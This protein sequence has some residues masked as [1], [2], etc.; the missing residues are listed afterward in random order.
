M[1]SIF[2]FLSFL[3]QIYLEAKYYNLFCYFTTFIPTNL[4]LY[5]NCIKGDDI[6]V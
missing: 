3:H 5:Y 4:I 6:Y 1:S 2:Y